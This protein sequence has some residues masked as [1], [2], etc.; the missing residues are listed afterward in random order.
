MPGTRRA[1]EDSETEKTQLLPSAPLSCTAAPLVVKI[2][3]AME[4]N[5][6]TTGKKE[7]CS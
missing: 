6:T 7:N 4:D 2:S 1:A 3:S 5:G